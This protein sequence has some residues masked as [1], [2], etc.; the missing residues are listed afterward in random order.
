M[1]NQLIIMYR[2]TNF[3]NDAYIRS[4]AEA[5]PK[6]KLKSTMTNHGLGS[7]I[8][9]FIDPH[10]ET[11]SIQLYKLNENTP[12]EFILENP[13]ILRDND[14]FED[15]ELTSDN[16]RFTRLSYNLNTLVTKIYDKYGDNFDEYSLTDLE[17]YKKDEI[18]INHLIDIDTELSSYYYYSFDEK[19]TDT[20]T[21]NK[22]IL[23][24]AINAFLYDYCCLQH[25]INNEDYVYMPI[26]YVLF[27]HKY[28]GI[29]NEGRNI[30]SRGSVKYIFNQTYGAR[31][32][33]SNY[34]KLYPLQGRL[35]FCLKN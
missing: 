34:K 24:N 30:A 23:I 8:Y 6:G 25:S 11:D 14:E 1:F 15:C 26:N 7:G 5:I 21:P 10:I 17:T 9:G 2:I 33:P 19:I 31:G 32:Y 27:M 3:Y 4:I 13:L 20:F 28:D 18:P 16:V 29:Y 12:K 22:Q 35:I